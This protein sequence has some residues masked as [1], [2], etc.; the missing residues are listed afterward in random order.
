MPKHVPKQSR[1][2]H[3]KK[4]NRAHRD[5]SVVWVELPSKKPR[6]VQPLPNGG[7]RYLT[8]P[9]GAIVMPFAMLAAGGIFAA[10]YYVVITLLGLS[11]WFLWVIF[12][13]FW[14]WLTESWWFGLTTRTFTDVY[15]DK[16]LIYGAFGCKKYVFWRLQCQFYYRQ[17][18]RGTP[19]LWVKRAK[20]RLPI[21][22]DNTLCADW[23]DFLCEVGAR[24]IF[25]NWLR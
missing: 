10:A 14:L 25:G 19:A 7:R 17:N 22:V 16:I 13:L 11:H 21:R 4:A 24:E 18:N 15:H 12:S 3:Y 8:S 23:E 2:P 6:Y 9:V 5:T 1:Q 20:H